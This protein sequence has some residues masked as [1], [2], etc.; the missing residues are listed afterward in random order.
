VTIKLTRCPT[1][2]S[3]SPISAIHTSRQTKACR[4]FGR[5]AAVILFLTICGVSLARA[6]GQQTPKPNPQAPRVIKFDGDMAYL[7]AT[8]ADSFETTIGLEVD[9]KQQKPQVSLYVRD[10]TLPDILNAIVKS[11]PAYQ[12]REQNGCFE[13]LPVEAGNPLLETIISNFRVSEVHQVEAFNRLM[14]L[15]EVQANL[16]A[17]SLNRRDPNRF[18]TDKKNEKFSMNLENVTMRQ[19]FSRIAH[20][21]GGR[22]W[23]FSAFGDGSFSISN[24]PG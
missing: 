14:N 5:I 19:A 23:I 6:T 16:R 17:M 8:L 13:V 18:S 24:S 21:S 15:P 22:F 1:N 20:E 7:L 9:P 3:F 11:A 12:W 10:A 4:T 2:F